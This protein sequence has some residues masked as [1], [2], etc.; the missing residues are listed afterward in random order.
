MYGA[1]Q[2]NKPAADHDHRL[3]PLWA[4]LRSLVEQLGPREDDK[5]VPAIEEVIRQIDAVDPGSFSFRYPT[6]KK[7][8]LSLPELWHVNVRHLGEVMNGVFMML[9]GIFYGRAR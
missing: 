6:N 3:M 7:G 1:W 9:G 8:E 2:K 5:E 4:E